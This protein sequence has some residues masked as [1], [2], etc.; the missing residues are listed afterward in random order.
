MRKYVI[1]VLALA[2]AAPVAAQDHDMAHHANAVAGVRGLYDAVKDFLTRSAEQMPEEHFA[3]KPTPDVRSF[4]EILGHVANAGYQFCNPVLG[5]ANPGE[6]KDAEKLT[7]KAD[8]VAALKASFAYCDRAYQIS[9]MAAM[10]QINFFGGQRTKLNVLEFN[11]GHDFEHYG[12]I[13]TYMRIKGL[14]PP[15]SQRM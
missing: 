9:D 15:S 12:N 1:P 5:G 6:G 10:E 7:K 14:V 2:M 8:V 11:M 4:G 3:F 13:V